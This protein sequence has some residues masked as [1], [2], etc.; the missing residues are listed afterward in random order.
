[1]TDYRE[2]IAGPS[3]VVRALRTCVL[4]LWLVSLSSI[5][6]DVPRDVLRSSTPPTG[7]HIN[8]QISSW[9][10]PLDA[11]YDDLTADQVRLLKS[12]YK[13][14]GDADEPPY[15]KNGLGPIV[16]KLSQFRDF[17]AGGSGDDRAHR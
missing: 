10:A 14:M 7:S 5:A 2:W 16:R 17:A 3:Y 13:N 6:D 9:I 12:Q 4:G 8:R 11:K 1:M 15:P